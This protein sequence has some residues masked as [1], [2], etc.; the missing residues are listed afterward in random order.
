M[1]PVQPSASVSAVGLGLR[2]IGNYCY[3]F[4]G[5][6][7]AAD[8]LQIELDFTSGSGFIHATFGFCGAVDPANINAGTKGLFR[9]N[10]NGLLVAQVKIGTHEEDMPTSYEM[11]LIVPPHTH[12]TV[13]NLDSSSTTTFKQMVYITGRVYGAE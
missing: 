7:N 11:N 5:E 6:Y 10:F 2:Y 1:A 12:V 13:T 3:A 8:A 9:V 4:S